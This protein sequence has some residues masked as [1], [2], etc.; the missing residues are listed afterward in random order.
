MRP[1]RE[2]DAEALHAIFSDP[3][4]MRYWDRPAWDDIAETRR[5]LAK[6]IDNPPDQS[7]EYA[8][9]RDGALIGRVA[10]WKRWE[11]G[12]LIHP[13]HWGQGL[14]TE[15]MRALI[16]EIA[17]R[18]PEAQTLTAEIDP[19]NI[20]SARLLARLGF[21]MTGLEERNFLYGGT[22]WCDTASYALALRQDE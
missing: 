2:D 7:L 17:A 16:A 19:R 15:A 13:D 4:A 3:R 12:Y 5:F 6:C 18:F 9:E 21:A 11:V 14:A 20:A 22:E 1:L 10:M 8:V